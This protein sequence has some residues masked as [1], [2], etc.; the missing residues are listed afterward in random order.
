MASKNIV[1]VLQ[2]E[3][4]FAPAADFAARARIKQPDLVRLRRQAAADPNGFWAELARRELTWHTPFTVTLDDSAA[5]NYRWFTDGRLNVSFNC[6]DVHLAQRGQKT[7]IIF[8]GE[9]GDT[10][11][12]SYSELH[13]EVCRFANALKAQGLRKGDRVAIYMPLVPETLVAMHACNRIGAIHSVVFGGFSAP[14]L[15]DRIE[16]TGARVLI[17]AD[18]GWRGGHPI[19]LKAAADKAL[20][21]GCRTIERVIV[22]KRT[23]RPVTMQRGRDLWWH[24]AIAE[25]AAVCEP[26]WVEAEHPLYLLYT[27]GSTGK[28]KGIQHS[29][30]GY[31]LGAK[32]TTQWVFDLRDD[33]VFWCTADVGWVTGHSYVAYGPLAAGATVMLYEGAPTTPDAGRFWKI[34]QDQGVSIFYTAPTAIRALMKLGDEIPARYDLSRLRL[35]GSVG[36]P[37]NPE[38]WMWYHRV[39]G[40]GRCPIVDTWWQ[41]ET[42]VILISPLPGVTPTKPGSC[43]LPL[44]GIE[45]DIVDERGQSVTRPDAGGYLV[46]R[47]PWPAMLRTIWGNNARYLAAYWEKFDGRFYVAGD[48]AHRD[49]DGYFWI[50]GRIDDVLNVAGHRLGTMEIESALVSHARVAEAAVVGKPHEIKGEAV[51]AYVVCRGQRPT[52]D[53]SALVG[54]L[55]TWV[56]EHLGAIAKPDEIRFADNLPKT[57]SG[58]IMRRLLRAIARGEAIT[59]DVS[60]LENPSILDQLRGVDAPAATEK[61]RSS[62]AARPAASR[63]APAKPPKAP[64][65]P[66]P[67]KPAAGKAARSAG[68]RAPAASSKRTGARSAAVKSAVKA[69]N[70]RPA[71]GKPA[72]GA[73]R[74]GS[75]AK[76]AARRAPLRRATKSKTPPRTRRKARA[77]R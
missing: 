65:A 2:E 59:Q 72:R 37:I 38:A 54:E 6:L 63:S 35:L 1:S 15:K 3:R 25:Q 56:A 44:P 62:K 73:K 71:K 20:A 24:E 34:C 5:P 55:R 23:G 32:M 53:T 74:A 45:A 48:S 31:L 77:K 67:A 69:K 46:I 22:L 4:T 11:R 19:E 27:S 18:G 66:K 52:G 51:F 7:A 76:T 57:R 10:R 39:I 9:P 13:A 16:D 17:T 14:A 42:G 43:T 40:R 58:K 12:L 61:P 28:P 68:T 49:K 21:E 60:T 41:T 64:K 29:S 47:K 36:E 26:E 30:G 70:R 75:S 33:D 8:E 50:M